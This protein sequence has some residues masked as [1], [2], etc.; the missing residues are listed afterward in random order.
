[1]KPSIKTALAVLVGTVTTVLALG[2]GGAG[3]SPS[4]TT[5][6]AAAH[7]SSSLTP[8]RPDAPGVHT[9]MLVGCISGSNC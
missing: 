2:L 8:P 4:G 7:S 5:P 1:M 3:V 6:T 9:A